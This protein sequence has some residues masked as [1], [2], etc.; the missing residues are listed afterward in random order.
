M[1][2]TF[3]PR[4]SGFELN[5]MFEPT[6]CKILRYLHQHRQG[7]TLED[8]K[9]YVKSDISFVEKALQKLTVSGIVVK[10]GDVYRPGADFS[11]FY[12][13]FLKIYEKVNKTRERQLLVRGVLSR[14]SQFGYLLRTES[15]IRVL[16][17]EGFDREGTEALLQEETKQGYIT[18]VKVCFRSERYMMSC[19]PYIPLSYVYYTRHALFDDY[20]MLKESWRRQGLYI[21]EEEYLLS[22]YP[23]ELTTP[24]QQ[25][26]EE[27]RRGIRER[28]RREA[29]YNSFF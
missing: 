28:L 26:L 12:Q 20:N 4:K 7:K 9:N 25:Y 21:K 15:L 19:P 14:V 2:I 24:G 18:R 23:P 11:R 1:K 5:D 10:S 8:I 16:E 27:E 29:Y 13:D 17:E 22:N 6:V 3:R